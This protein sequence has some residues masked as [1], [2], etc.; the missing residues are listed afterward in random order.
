MN[1]PGYPEPGGKK[2]GFILRKI[3]EKTVGSKMHYAE[4]INLEALK[5][6]LILTWKGRCVFHLEKNPTSVHLKETEGH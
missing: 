4:N 2:T 6:Q 3:R 1:Q 5:Q